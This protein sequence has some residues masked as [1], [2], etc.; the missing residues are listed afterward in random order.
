M[1]GPSSDSRWASPGFVLARF[2]RLPTADP[3][4]YRASLD[5][6]GL[7]Q[8]ARGAAAARRGASSRPPTQCAVLVGPTPRSGTNFVE[9]LIAAHPLVA[10]APLGLRELPVLPEAH[11]LNGFAQALASRHPSNA[12]LGPADWLA[13]ALAGLLQRAAAEAPGAE[14]VLLKDPH[15]RRLDLLRAVLPDATPVIVLRDGMRTIDSAVATW[16]ARGLSRWL[17]R[18]FADH[19]RDWA[20]ATEAALDFARNVPEALVLRYEDAASA[21]S[22]MAV[23][24]WTALGLEVDAEAERAAAVLPILGSST[25]SRGSAGVD[26]TPRE[27]PE[28]FDPAARHVRWSARRRRIFLREAGAVQARLDRERPVTVGT[29]RS[30]DTEGHEPVRLAEFRRTERPRRIKNDERR[31]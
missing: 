14:I 9:A 29:R 25:H 5:A 15:T 17:G 23:R 6:R 1:T 21:P 28:G 11:R 30:D 26:W 7:A 24:L 10:A 20:L 13:L 31:S 18:S 19:C 2:L 16:P 27:R 12:A 22:A 8:V 3:R 4:W